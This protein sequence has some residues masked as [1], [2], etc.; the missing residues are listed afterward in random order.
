MLLFRSEEH[1]EAWLAS[2]RGPRGERMTTALQWELARLW[3]AGRD[4]PEWRPRTAAQAQE[5]FGEA[6]LR[7]DFWRLA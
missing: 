5:V 3:F 1:L 7:G 2:G 4:R 6:G